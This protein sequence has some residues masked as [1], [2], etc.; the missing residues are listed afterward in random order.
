MT[1][2]LAALLLVATPFAGLA[3]T[4]PAADACTGPCAIVCDVW[5]SKPA[6]NVLGPCNLD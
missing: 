6:S 4:A 3:F 5:N 1:R 2:R